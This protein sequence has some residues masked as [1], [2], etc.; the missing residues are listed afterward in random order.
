MYNE[1][2]ARLVDALLE[3]QYDFDDILRAIDE[4]A[5]EQEVF[6]KLKQMKENPSG[7]PEHKTEKSNSTEEYKIIS[8]NVEERDEHKIEESRFSRAGDSQTVQKPPTSSIGF[9]VGK[10]E[11]NPFIP[12]NKELPGPKQLKFNH[13]L[14]VLKQFKPK[15]NYFTEIHPQFQAILLKDESKQPEEKKN[16]EIPISSH[17]PKSILKPYSH[18]S[19]IQSKDDIISHLQSL[20]TSFETAKEVASFT[21]TLEEAAL[22]LG[23]IIPTDYFSSSTNPSIGQKQVKF[24][25]PEENDPL[26]PEVDTAYNRLL[27]PYKINITDNF[28]LFLDYSFESESSL[29]SAGTK[30]I[31]Q[32]LEAMRKSL[33]C[34][35]TASVFCLVFGSNMSKI[36]C[37]I[38]GIAD[39]P[40]AHGLYLF[41]VFLPSTYPNSPPQ[42][43]FRTTGNYSFR[44]N[45]NLYMNGKICLSIINT[46]QG[47]T[48]EMWNPRNSSLMQ[49]FLSIQ[50]LVMDKYVIQKEPGFEKLEVDSPENV[51]YR[52]EAMYG[53]IK[54]AILD[55]I[56]NPI[57]GFEEVIRLHFSSKK[58]EILDT[59][60]ELVENSKGYIPPP[61]L[62]SQNPTLYARFQ[63]ENV[64][65]IFTALYY[66]LNEALALPNFN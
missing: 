51:L 33:P 62:K 40:Y 19:Q 37:L 30:R 50:S 2:K 25:E 53:N 39:S 48:D 9:K 14:K 24:N 17:I 58:K 31:N 60:N 21:D 7:I 38:S 16:E 41:D 27:S 65:E 52:Y 56:R 6:D 35:S 45:P 54:Y 32:E 4:S 3:Q 57:R 36:R 49:V 64:H 1:A 34:D 12:G 55:H 43:F 47:N 20:G 15:L 8:K 66:E 29:D 13:Q 61:G 42:V 5:D 23:I 22:N 26:P 18:A 28:E 44:F 59:V 46:W 11:L 10:S 63:A